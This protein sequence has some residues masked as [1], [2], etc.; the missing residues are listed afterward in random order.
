MFRRYLHFDM[1]RL[2]GGANMLYIVNPQPFSQ[3]VMHL[4]KTPYKAINHDCFLPSMFDKGDAYARAVHQLVQAAAGRQKN[5]PVISITTSME[6]DPKY[7]KITVALAVWHASA[8]K[9]K[10]LYFQSARR[11]KNI[12]KYI[13]ERKPFCSNISYNILGESSSFII[14]GV[15]D[16]VDM[17]NHTQHHLRTL[18]GTGGV[19]A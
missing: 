6:S 1:M 10:A 11:S 16:I 2:K 18:L 12:T 19:L 13:T 17:L 15:H 3:A 5:V 7:G 4:L 9:T 8:F 14:D